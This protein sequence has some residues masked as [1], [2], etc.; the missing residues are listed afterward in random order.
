M[1]DRDPDQSLEAE[2]IPE[3]FDAPPGRDVETNEEA[4][5]APRDYPIAAGQDPAYP[6]T[7]AE[8]R[9]Q[10]TVAERAE[11]EE[12]DLGEVEL[13]DGGLGGGGLDG[14]DEGGAPLVGHLMSPDSGV[15]SEDLTS[16]EVG[17]IGEDDGAGLS[18]EEAAVHL[19]SEDVAD[20]VDPAVE[21]AEYLEDR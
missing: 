3:T 16:E 21:A 14:E 15:D 18:A 19:A 12:P 17:L 20:D 2:G 11:R 5:M 7:A 9:V 8:D 10:E 13:A 1:S 6:V 4:S